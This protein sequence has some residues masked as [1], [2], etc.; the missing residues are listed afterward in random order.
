[1]VLLVYQRKN[2]SPARNR[3]QQLNMD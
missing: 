2:L 3:T 1:L